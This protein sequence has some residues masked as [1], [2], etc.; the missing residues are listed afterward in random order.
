VIDPPALAKLSPNERQVLILLAQG[1]TTKSIASLLGVSAGAVNERLR[2]ARRKTGAA[3][4]RRTG[5][6][7]CPGKS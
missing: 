1:H 4:S 7:A 5:P 2:E 3:S 6:R